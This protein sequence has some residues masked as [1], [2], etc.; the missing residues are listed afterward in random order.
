MNSLRYFSH[1][2]TNNK[3]TKTKEEK[4]KLKN[5]AFFGV[6][7]SILSVASAQAENENYIA[8]KGYVDSRVG[9]VTT[10]LGDNY[11]TKSEMDTE[12]AGKEDTIEDLATIRSGAAAGA[13]AVQPDAI[14]DMETKTHAAATYATQSD[15]TTE[16]AKKQNTLTFDATP[17]A[18]ST[19]PVTSGGVKA[20]IDALPQA[21]NTYTKG[22]VDNALAG[23]EDTISD[24]E[25]IRSGAAAGATA[26]QP[27]AISDM[28]TQTHASATYATKSDM[29]TELAGKQ[30]TISDLATIRSGAAAG[31]TALQ[32]TSA[33][34]G[35]KLT[36]GSV[37]KTALATAVQNA[38][39]NALVKNDAI[40]AST[41]NSIVQYDAK[42]L[43]K[44]GTPAGELATATLTA[45]PDNMKCVVTRNAN[46]TYAYTP[47]QD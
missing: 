3:Q 9:T 14:T 43:V 30:D 42:G 29:T 17:T 5:L 38:I 37:A 1:T 10:N 45:C 23:K 32:P 16:L 25:T 44:S 33:L 39:D 2:T 27:A 40:T 46:G 20:A 26:V 28:E 13:T 22:E 8:S 12:L 18:N 19:N 31:A 7:A 21:D 11:Y 35:S 4:M 24:L 15:M 34:D 36:D 6:M 47:I 41:A